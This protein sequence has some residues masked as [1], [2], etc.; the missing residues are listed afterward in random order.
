MQAF[1]FIN[2]AVVY[3]ALLAQGS[4]SK[5]GYEIFIAHVVSMN[6]HLSAT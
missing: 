4:Y 3:Q 5:L 1:Y 2:N 6:L